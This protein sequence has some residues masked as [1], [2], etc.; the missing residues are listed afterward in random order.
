[1][2]VHIGTMNVSG[3]SFGHRGKCMKT[4]E[5]LLKI[6]PGEKLRE[7]TEMMKTHGVSLMTVTD[8]HLS[9]EGMGEVH[10]YLRQ[11]GLGGGGIAA[12]R[13]TQGGISTNT[14]RRAGVYHVWDPMQTLVDDIEEVYESR[15]ARARI[16]LLDSGKELEVYEVYMPER[17]N[18]G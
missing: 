15:V 5:D 11:E 8:T 10:K 7:V 16:Q 12:K 13:E 2:E 1:M 9:Q 14:R 4:E 6:R 17:C 3:I 18:N